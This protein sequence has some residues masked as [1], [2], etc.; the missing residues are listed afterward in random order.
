LESPLSFVRREWQALTIFGG[1]YVIV[2]LIGV[3]AVDPAYF[4]PRLGT[5]PLL[6]YLKGL[7]FAETGHTAARTAINRKPFNYAAMPGVMRAPFMMMFS[8]FDTQLRAI[9]LS[10]IVL[11]V[12]TAVMF[13][14]V[15]S[16]VL[17]RSRHWIAIA[18][19]F[20][21]LL[22]SPN[23]VANVFEPLADAPYAAFTMATLILVSRVV[24]SDR[25]IRKRPVAIV[26]GAFLFAMAFMVKFTAPVILLYVAVLAAGRP[27]HHAIPRR[28]KSVA[29]LSAIAGVA[30]LV[31]LN[32]GAIVNRYLP[33][34]ILFL[35]RASKTGMLLNLTTL[36]IPANIIPVYH[37]LARDPAHPFRPEF[38]LTPVD[39][40]FMAVGIGISLVMFYGMWRT[41]DRL[42]PEIIYF[43]AAL[44]VL[45]VII[46]STRRYLMP[47]EPL[48]WIFFYV[49]A[50]VMLRSILK[51]FKPI[52]VPPAVGLA[53]ALLVAFA[54]LAVR[55]Q[56][57]VGTGSNRRVGIT[58]GQT[59]G[60]VVEVSST[61]RD[62]RRFLEAL[63]RE[64][65]LLIGGPG[66]GGRWKAI[67][68][69]NYYSPDSSLNVAAR[70]H[71]VYVLVECGAVDVCQDFENWDGRFRRIL[72]DRY[73]PFV[74][75]PVFSRMTE[76]A[77]ARVYR[78]TNPQ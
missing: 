18:F 12:V 3:L 19:T 28:V 35:R 4:Y 65:S 40:I 47:Y 44:P 46:P 14:Y 9:Q 21:F 49:G 1:V 70:T 52:N 22:I 42:L 72:D 24:A 64:R 62:L 7:A 56:R 31:Y 73:G 2:L 26:T 59:R 33:E 61:F 37:L 30:L 60:Y 50:G 38:G 51:R 54:L 53:F 13:A 68:G 63:P 69:L 58:I 34:P 76:H 29:W 6:Y 55:S 39:I 11:I 32:W 57:M 36:S 23:W 77:K 20:G 5:D 10:N 75:A 17:P 16:W 25:P 66:A 67:S 27:R 78:L 71:D 48:I 41:R 45:T 8:E 15:L 74:Y 43:L